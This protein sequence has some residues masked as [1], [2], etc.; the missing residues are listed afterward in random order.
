[1]KNPKLILATGADVNYYQR[2]VFQ[3]YI[4]SIIQNSDFDKNFIVLLDGEVEVDSF[5]NIEV[6]SVKSSDISCL[7][8]IN[9]LQHGE[10]TKSDK[11]NSLEDEDV[12]LFSDGD[13]IIQRNLT[14]SEKNFLL[15]LKDN[16]VFVGYNASPD[17]TLA[18]ESPRL[19][20]TSYTSDIIKDDLTK[21]K[22]YNTGVLCMN[23]KTWNRLAD[24]YIN[25]FSEVDKMFTHYAKQQWLICYVLHING[26]KVY[27]MPYDFHTHTHYPAPQGITIEPNG[28]VKYLDNTVLFKHRFN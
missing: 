24:E 20:P 13:M 6:T 1:M 28:L 22:V 3:K 19:N 4:N 11:I 2:P 18:N 8:S 17:D 12:I 26:Y 14:L 15:N 7:T 23:K 16:E 27:E 25:L 21:I 5:Y 10:F 9:C